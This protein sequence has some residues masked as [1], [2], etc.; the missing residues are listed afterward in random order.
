MLGTVA[1]HVSI[2]MDLNDLVGGKKAVAD[3]LLQ[4]IGIDRLAEAIDVG[5]VLGFLGRGGQ[6]DLGGR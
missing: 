4:G 1:F 3:A 5:N 2:D 6:A